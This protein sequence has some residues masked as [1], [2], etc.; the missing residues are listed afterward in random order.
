MPVTD[1]RRRRV[2]FHIVEKEVDIRVSEGILRV[3]RDFLNVM[4][5]EEDTD[6]RDGGMA[7]HDIKVGSKNFYLFRGL[8]GKD[9]KVLLSDKVIVNIGVVY[10]NTKAKGILQV[11]Q[12][13]FLRIHT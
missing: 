2:G 6:E 1:K 5:D 9:V 13:N 11:S 8:H 7:V 10:I 12:T 4:D 3:I